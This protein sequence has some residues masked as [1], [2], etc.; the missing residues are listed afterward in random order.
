[1]NNREWLFIFS[2]L[3]IWK[4]YSRHGTGMTQTFSVTLVTPDQNLENNVR[5]IFENYAE[6]DLTAI[7][8]N[9]FS[10]E[11]YLKKAK[12]VILLVEIGSANE[13]DLETLSRINAEPQSAPIIVISDSLDTDTVRKLLH[14]GVEDWLPKSALKDDL[15]ASCQKALQNKPVKVQQSSSAC[16]AFVPAVGG[17]GTTTLAIE[18]AFRLANDSFKQ[19]KS[20]CIVD[21]NFQNGTVSDYL[22]L[23]PGLEVEEIASRPD[24]LDRQLLEV[25]LSR[26]NSGI[27]VL[28]APRSTTAF[29]HVTDD[30]VENILG[31]VSEM[32][33]NFII[34]LPPVWFSWTDSVV[35]GADKMF[36]VTEF[37]IPALQ[38]ASKLAEE[39]QEKPVNSVDT[40]ILINKH[41]QQ[42]IGS[43]L[44]KQDA[45]EIV[46]EHNVHFISEDKKFVEEAINRGE[47]LSQVRASNRISKELGKVLGLQ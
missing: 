47:P 23:K 14:M 3:W 27:S 46:G 17:V 7:H 19:N 6:Y 40:H 37:T 13:L 22:D 28:S 12:S 20:T 39:I 42:L 33:D 34:D 35:H 45:F 25:M 5:S 44:M 1:M 29:Q 24:R 10:Q 30:L 32:F 38:Y 16:Y 15:I 18:A 26:H 4:M 8:G 11:S 2:R 9:I 43:G 36:I 21:L 41:K 31:I